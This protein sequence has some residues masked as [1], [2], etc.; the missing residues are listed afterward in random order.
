MAPVANPGQTPVY[1]NMGF[2]ILGYIIERHTGHSFKNVVQHQ[3]LDHLDLNETSVF[4]PRDTQNAV[5]PVNQKTSGWLD[6][7]PGTEA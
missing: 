4:A 1:S 7:L 5:I 2:Q 6:H 3:I